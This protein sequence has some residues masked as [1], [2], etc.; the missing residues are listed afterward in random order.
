[1]FLSIGFAVLSR[2]LEWKI[3]RDTV[4]VRQIMDIYTLVAAF[5]PHPV[6]Q[7]LTAAAQH[8]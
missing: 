3:D 8:L 7:G 1:M 5:H 2:G 4:A 6:P